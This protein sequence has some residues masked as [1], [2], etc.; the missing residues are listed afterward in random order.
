MSIKRRVLYNN[1][2]NYKIHQ[3]DICGVTE[4]AWK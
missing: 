4:Q 1:K 2:N 3:K